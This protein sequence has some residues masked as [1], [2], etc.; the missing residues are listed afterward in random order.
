MRKAGEKTPF[1]NTLAALDARGYFVIPKSRIIEEPEQWTI[2]KSDFEKRGKSH[3]MKKI[4]HS[5]FK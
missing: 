2:L 1:Q 5:R 4:A 3:P